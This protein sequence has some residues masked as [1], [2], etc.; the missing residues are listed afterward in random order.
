ME[1]GVNMK[2]SRYNL[3]FNTK[4]NKKIAFNSATCSLAEVEEKKLDNLTDKEK[5]ILEQA[6]LGG[7]VVH[8]KLDELKVLKYKNNFGKF[9]QHSLGLTIAPTLA[10]NF[11]CTYCYET[12]KSVKMSD[13]VKQGII[14]YAKT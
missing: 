10:C 3:I 9:N 8:S 1:D 11:R 7:Y 5:E 4:N 13:E 14:D 6:K 12:P 2:K